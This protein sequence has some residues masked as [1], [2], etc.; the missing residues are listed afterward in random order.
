MRSRRPKQ[1]KAF[2]GEYWDNKKEG[3]YVAAVGAQRSRGACGRPPGRLLLKSPRAPACTPAL[4]AGGLPLFSSE[5]KFDS[6]TG[7]APKGDERPPP[8]FPLPCRAHARTA[9]GCFRPHSSSC[10]RAP[11]WPSFSAPIDPDHIVEQPDFTMG[12]RRVEIVCARSGIHLGHVFN[13]GP[14]PTGKRY[15]VNSAALK[16]V[17]KVRC[18]AGQHWRPL[19]A[20]WWAQSCALLVQ[21]LASLLI[22]SIRIR[23]P[24]GVS[25]ATGVGASGP[26][27]VKRVRH[28][29]TTT[30]M[31]LLQRQQQG[32]G[33]AA[34]A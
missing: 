32:G 21:S 34:A 19:R 26:E 23:R 25:D 17:P 30:K 12:M 16:F 5:T 14:P 28:S 22:R 8:F 33:T 4:A 31:A 7:A 18:G 9:P 11:G 24:A 6:G 13:D 2:T 27:E 1:E 10:P 15:C 29:S 20:C 3:V